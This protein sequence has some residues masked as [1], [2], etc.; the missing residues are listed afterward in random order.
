MS[1]TP[2]IYAALSDLMVDVVIFIPETG[3]NKFGAPSYGTSFT[4]RGRLTNANQRVRTVAGV[5]VTDVGKFICYG[6]H[7]EV[8]VRHKMVVNSIQYNIN[9]TNSVSDENGTH[10]TDIYFGH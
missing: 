3:E 6:P 2:P 4:I 10:H 7:T 1:A 9:S 5:E 8:T